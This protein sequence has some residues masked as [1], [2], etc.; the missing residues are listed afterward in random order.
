[1]VS[2]LKEHLN[3]SKLHQGCAKKHDFLTFEQRKNLPI[4]KDG[5]ILCSLCLDYFKN[6]SFDKHKKNCN[7]RDSTTESELVS[8]EIVEEILLECGLVSVGRVETVESVEPIQ[9]AVDHRT[10]EVENANYLHQQ[11]EETYEENIVVPESEVKNSGLTEL[12]S[13]FDSVDHTL[14]NSLHE[15]QREKALFMTENLKRIYID[16]EK[17]LE[18]RRERENEEIAVIEVFQEYL[19]YHSGSCWFTEASKRQGEIKEPSTKEGLLKTLKRKWLPFIRGLF[20]SP[21]NLLHI[22]ENSYEDNLIKF[23]H[24]LQMNAIAGRN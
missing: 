1:M 8:K 12:F 9:E 23:E 4:T 7:R 6:T 18:R 13:Q 5:K 19:E 3:G 20:G 16:H 11:E 24:I 21:A 22:D 14:V 15:D 17:V 10:E 2:R